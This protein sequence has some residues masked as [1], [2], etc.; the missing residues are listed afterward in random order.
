MP[1][2]VESPSG[3]VPEKAPRWD[4]TGTEAC[5]GG[6][7]FWWTLLLVWEYLGIY[8]PKIRVRRPP[9]GPQVQGRAPTACHRL[10]GLLTSS[11]SLV[12]VFWSKKNHHKSFIPFGLRLIFLFCEA[13]KHEKIETG[14][15]L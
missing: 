2:M 4:L 5:G 8:R 7:V 15:G 9:R 6:K 12:G 10:V 13:K 14:T 11:P 3:R 1:S